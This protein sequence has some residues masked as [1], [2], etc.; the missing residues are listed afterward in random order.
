MTIQN[1]SFYAT[2]LLTREL[3]KEL[4]K[5]K[6]ERLLIY[7]EEW[8]KLRHLIFSLEKSEQTHDIPPFKVDDVKLARQLYTKLRE[9][10]PCNAPK[11]IE[12]SYS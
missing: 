10:F 12:I 6:R 11:E 7:I 4:N 2:Q 1:C 8:R 3:L 5:I 9:I